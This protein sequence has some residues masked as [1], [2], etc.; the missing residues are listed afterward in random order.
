MAGREG[1]AGT[2][3][4]GAARREDVARPRPSPCEEPSLNRLPALPL[5]A[6]ALSAGAASPPGS[7][8]DAPAVSGAQRVH[9]EPS[10]Q[11]A[12]RVQRL[13][14][15]AEDLRRRIAGHEARR[16]TLLEQA[17]VLDQEL[18]LRRAEAE[19]ARAAADGEA[20][21]AARAL[22]RAAALGGR[23]A[24]LRRHAAVIARALYVEGDDPL[25]RLVLG[26]PTRGAQVAS[27]TARRAADLATEVR[28]AREA[29][30]EAAREAARRAASAGRAREHAERGERAAAQQAGLRR[31]GLRDLAARASADE[32]LLE[33]KAAAAQELSA[34][35]APSAL[36]RRPAVAGPASADL[37]G[38]E[39]RRGLLRWPL[40]G[41]QR[42]LETWGTV[43]DP[44]R[45]TRTFRHG[46]TLEARHG[47][48]IR[49]VADGRVLFVDWYKGFGRC[50][51]LDH[52]AGFLS[53]YA[54][55]EEI[56]VRPGETVRE[57][58]VIGS[59]GDTGSLDGPRLFLQLQRNGESV[60]PM[61]WLAR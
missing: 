55:A 59:A 42:V 1:P 2:G 4:P 31:R 11:M 21:G 6:A 12:Q 46:V 13:R 34:S 22:E 9:V 44:R 47:D 37:R 45:G 49:A 39:A 51:V 7:P 8:R 27:V 57:G 56:G 5:L 33:E 26:E 40:D 17:R 35:L 24:S 16:A 20:A 41:R 43:V 30:A 53:V 52:G 29:A 19:S 3:R 15:E 61:Q 25:A 60:D 23:E 18:A 10:P 50:L 28:R 32:R 58:D 14:D 54:H 48:A 38:L 36:A